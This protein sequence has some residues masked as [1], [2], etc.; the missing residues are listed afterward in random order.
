ML[1]G[2]VSQRPIDEPDYNELLRSYRSGHI[3]TAT[4]L[5]ARKR[6]FQFRSQLS[7]NLQIVSKILITP[8]TV[9]I[10]QKTDDIRQASEQ[11]HQR[12]LS[13]SNG[14][15]GGESLNTSVSSSAQQPHELAD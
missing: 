3:F 5:P 10:L 1:N 7:F 9:A 15:G 6:T 8:F 11:L 12:Q 4:R 13:Q 14:G 2:I